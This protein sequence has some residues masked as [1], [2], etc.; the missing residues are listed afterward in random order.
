MQF[1]LILVIFCLLKSIL[2]GKMCFCTRLGK[3]AIFLYFC[4]IFYNFFFDLS[5]KTRVF[6]CFFFLW[7]YPM[8]KLLCR[9]V[10]GTYSI[11]CPNLNLL[12]RVVEG[13]TML[14]VYLHLFVQLMNLVFKL[15]HL[16]WHW[17]AEIPVPWH[18]FSGL[19]HEK[20]SCFQIWWLWWRWSRPGEWE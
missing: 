20:G 18:I 6:I 16:G 2:L 12:C 11:L 19:Y 9:V 1:A 7:L 14:F 10:E 17:T 15:V 13:T 4:D 8:L 3:T 5:E